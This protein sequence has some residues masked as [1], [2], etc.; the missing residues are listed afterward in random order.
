[1]PTLDSDAVLFRQLDKEEEE[2]FR[3]W[4]RMNF[5]PGDT[6]S[7]FWHPVVRDECQRMID[8]EE[9]LASGDF[10]ISKDEEGE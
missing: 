9:A 6:I 5:R 10:E 1:M 2:R 7:T 4:A 8:A 3:L